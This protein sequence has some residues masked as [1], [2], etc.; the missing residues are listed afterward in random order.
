MTPRKGT[1]RVI[2]PLL[3]LYALGIALL[4]SLPSDQAKNNFQNFD[5]ISN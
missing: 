3:S 2:S 5:F 4:S 1:P